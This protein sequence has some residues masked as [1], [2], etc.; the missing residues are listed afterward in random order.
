M[1]LICD[2]RLEENLSWN[3]VKGRYLG[4]AFE[5]ESVSNN[6][7]VVRWN[8]GL[9]LI[10]WAAEGVT[11]KFTRLDIS[12]GMEL[13]GIP[14]ASVRNRKDADYILMRNV[15]KIAASNRFYSYSKM[16]Y[17]KWHDKVFYELTLLATRY[18]SS[19]IFCRGPYGLTSSQ[20]TIG[21]QK[22]LR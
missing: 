15:V 4:T 14:M 10:R 21:C 5:I 3:T 18:E 19:S 6:K 2:F 20:R 7:L 22:T 11:K 16:T 17:Y 12:K 8:G 1:D 13:F 9:R